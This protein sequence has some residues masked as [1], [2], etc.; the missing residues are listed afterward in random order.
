MEP[1]YDFF[2]NDFDINNSS[3]IEQT[4]LSLTCDASF[5]HKENNDLSLTTYPFTIT[6]KD[7]SNIIFLLKDFNGNCEEV[8]MHIQKYS[9]DIIRYIKIVKF[10][11]VSPKENKFTKDEDSLLLDLV[12]KYGLNFSKFIRNFNKTANELKWRYQ[13]LQIV[14]DIFQ[15]N[16]PMNSKSINKLPEIITSLLYENSSCI[17]SKSNY[18]EPLSVIPNKS[19]SINVASDLQETDLLN[20]KNE[21]SLRIKRKKEKDDREAKPIFQINEIKKISLSLNKIYL[22]L[23]MHL[24]TINEQSNNTLITES[25][26]SSYVKNEKDN[27]FSLIQSFK[28]TILEQYNLI[29]KDFIYSIQLFAFNITENKEDNEKNYS[30]NNSLNL[31]LAKVDLLF[32][33]IKL[34][35][36]NGK[37]IN[38]RL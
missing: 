24:K 31:L 6:K 2:Y 1:E 18:K 38:S 30:I 36:V 14:Y 29:D 7:L 27:Y 16:T 5:N 3:I 9:L 21:S 33:L 32:Q 15:V 25:M 8:H 37:L 26:I 23:F 13:K 22:Y 19:K 12:S 4:D 35:R 17:F 34:I 11:R 10:Y 20:N 28:K